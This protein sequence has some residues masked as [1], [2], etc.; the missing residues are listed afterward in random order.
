MWWRTVF[1]YCC[2]MYH[3]KSQTALGFISP[4]FLY[5]LNHTAGLIIYL[6]WPLHAGILWY[7]H[8]LNPK[9]WPTL[10]FLLRSS[11]NL[12][13][14][15]FDCTV[16]CTWLVL[17]VMQEHHSHSHSCQLLRPLPAVHSICS[18]Q[19]LWTSAFS[20]LSVGLVCIWNIG[21]N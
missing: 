15:F 7:S 11:A 13:C 1:Q 2:S 12:L 8:W 6:H 14:G 18:C 3:I 4:L 5:D 16:L 10:F 9:R 17:W 20:F 21:F 19:G